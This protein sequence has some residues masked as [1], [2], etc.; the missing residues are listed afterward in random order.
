MK[1]RNIP[2]LGAL[3]DSLYI[4]L[5]VLSF[6]NFFAI[7]TVLYANIHPFLQEYLPWLRF[8]MFLAIIG[9]LATILAL[10]VYKFV[11]PSLWTYRS[12]QMFMHESEITAKLDELIGKVDGLEEKKK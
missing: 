3:V 6:V 5:P 11:I 1:Q 7:L 2:W 10:L 4:S 8:W 12:K 9:V